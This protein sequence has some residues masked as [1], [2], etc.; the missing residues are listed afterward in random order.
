MGRGTKF[1][2]L[3]VAGAALAAHLALSVGSAPGSAEEAYGLAL[4]IEGGAVAALVT[5]AL[6]SSDGRA[7]WGMLAAGVLCWAIGD[8]VY[9]FAGDGVGADYAPLA[10]VAYWGFYGFSIAGLFFLGR[11]RGTRLRPTLPTVVALLGLLTAW[12]YLVF[13]SVSTQGADPSTLTYPLL[14]LALVAAVFLSFSQGGARVA[15]ATIVLAVSFLVSAVVDG[16]VAAEAGSSGYVPGAWTETLWPLAIVL[17]AAAA[18]TPGEFTVSERLGTATRTGVILLSGLVALGL[19]VFDH[20]DRLDTLTFV[21][22]GVTLFVAVCG[23]VDAQRRYRLA[24]TAAGAAQLASDLRGQLLDQVDAAVVATDTEGRIAFWSG[25]AERLLGWSADE[26]VGKTSRELGTIDDAQF[27]AA[28]AL[29]AKAMAGKAAAM[30][31]ELRH[32]DGHR[33]EA[34]YRITALRAPDGSVQGVAGVV[35]DLTVKREYE[36][37]LAARAE[38]QGAVAD[39]GRRVAGERDVPTLANNAA[40]TVRRVLRAD[41]VEV[42]ELVPGEKE[43]SV[44]AASGLRAD[45]VMVASIP[46]EGSRAGF[47]LRSADSV[48]VDDLA[49]ERR[50]PTCDLLG[51]IGIT[52]GA[53]AVIHG[54]GG[55]AGVIS[56]HCREPRT[57][58][59]DEVNF[60]ESIASVLAAAIA[61]ERA[62]ALAEQLRQ[63]QKLEDI[64]RLTGGIAHDFNNLLA[65][66]LNYVSFVH[67]RLP[68]GENRDDLAEALKASRSAAELTER[69]LMFSRQD[70]HRAEETIHLDPAIDDVVAL[71]ERTIGEDIVLTTDLGSGG[72]AV[73][74]AAGEVQQVLMNLAVNAR[75]AMPSGG[76]LLIRTERTIVDARPQVRVSVS[77]TGAGM[78]EEVQQHAADPFFTT[79]EA[80]QG[81]GLGLGIVHG[82]AAQAGGS[83][84]I[85]SAPGRGTTISL[86]LPVVEHTAESHEPPKKL[87][88]QGN[89]EI[90]LLVEDAPQLRH[91]TERILRKG[92]YQPLAAA[93]PSEALEIS[94]DYNGDLALLLTDIIMPEMSGID[95]AERLRRT[96]PSLA[97]AFMSG[98]AGGVSLERAGVAGAAT[99]IDKPFDGETLVAAVHETLA[100]R[101]G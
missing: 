77:D 73:G 17:I 14:D 99:F 95:L 72:A 34:L 12:S 50:F 76:A 57:F 52:C 24:R 36:R 35:V 74:L 59:S 65:L 9:Y 96:H 3:A 27:A 37:A 7:G 28:S 41:L 58:S 93:T 97:V 5:R 68:A 88:A 19:L 91:L 75:D 31:L 62:D 39:L 10:D 64:G 90:V 11:D 6:T 30:E 29:R 92:G 45:D 40:E 47:A 25:G 79:K 69:L 48:V 15:R 85:D 8:G 23:A 46:L 33:F 2:L 100:N 20:Y 82:I 70:R 55:P 56:A 4:I 53:T 22:A 13:S 49:S 80:G 81:T 87:S 78:S 32:K 101:A 94:R 42:L 26:A 43:L 89:G 16:M 60:L 98:Y 86:T 63:A 84:E 83:V 66:I 18:W 61:R 21:L 1:T 44:R 51:E 38:Q 71:L 54:P 67:D